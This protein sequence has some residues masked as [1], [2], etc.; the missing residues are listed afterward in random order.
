MSKQTILT[1]TLALLMPSIVFADTVLVSNVADNV[2]WN[3]VRVPGGGTQLYDSRTLTF[4]GF[5]GEVIAS[6]S[7]DLELTGTYDDSPALDLNG[8]G[9]IDWAT[10]QSDFYAAGASYSP[11]IDESPLSM[12]VTVTPTGT[13]VVVQW[14]GVVITPGV[15]GTPGWNDAVS[16]TL[17]DLGF[18]PG[19]TVPSDSFTTNEIRL[20]NLNEAG[21]SG[22][23]TVF[24]IPEASLVIVAVPEPATGCL[25]VFAATAIAWRRRRSFR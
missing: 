21:P 14:D 18:G 5:D 23:G 10:T 1:L 6:L 22:H 4:D 24:T 11:W 20:G 8:D 13:N 9:V 19:G 2:A 25:F 16:M 3:D 15:S 12:Q 17:E 7:F